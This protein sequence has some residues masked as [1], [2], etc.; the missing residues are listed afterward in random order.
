MAINKEIYQKFEIEINGGTISAGQFLSKNFQDRIFRG[1]FNVFSST[2]SIRKLL[3][4]PFKVKRPL[5]DFP[6]A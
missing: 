6:K 5:G 4:M 1:L 3:E 2:L